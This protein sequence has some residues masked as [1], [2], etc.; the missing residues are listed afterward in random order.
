MKQRNRRRKGNK[1]WKEEKEEKCE[2]SGSHG[3][4]YEEETTRRYIPQNCRQRRKVCLY[5]TICA[6]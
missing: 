3:G 1:A 6:A 5:V 4:E 2:I